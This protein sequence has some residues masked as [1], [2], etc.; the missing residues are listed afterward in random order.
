M[1]PAVLA[2]CVRLT[3]AGLLHDIGK[4]V[5]GEYEGSHAHIGA[6]FIKRYGETPIVV[7]AVAAHH[8]E[9][10]PETVYAG[11][12][13]GCFC[14]G[15]PASVNLHATIE[16]CYL[17]SSGLSPWS[18]DELLRAKRAGFNL[19]TWGDGYG[20]VLVATGRVEAMYDPKAE[21]YDVAPMPVITASFR[22]VDFW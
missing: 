6:E 19:R 9:V 12:G 16:G 10:K 21:L 20:Y 2:L 22:P 1:M 4:A 5:D 17:T 14:N 18:D 11:R 8:E 3:R 13:L 15:V 7:N